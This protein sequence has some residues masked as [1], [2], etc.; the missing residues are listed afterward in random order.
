MGRARDN[1][2]L[3]AI[4]NTG[5]VVA[6]AVPRQ[7][8]PELLSG[9]MSIQPLSTQPSARARRFGPLHLINTRSLQANARIVRQERELIQ[10]ETAL[11][12]R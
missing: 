5:S 10:E 6:R 12:S 8:I 7:S 9:T 1:D 2:A 4:R 11:G 3:K